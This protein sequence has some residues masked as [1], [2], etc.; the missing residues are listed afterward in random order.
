MRVAFCLGAV[1]RWAGVWSRYV[2]SCYTRTHS[3]HAGHPRATMQRGHED[4]CGCAQSTLRRA[5]T[6]PNIASPHT[7]TVSFTRPAT[8]TQRR[9][10][11]YTHTSPCLPNVSRPH[12]PKGRVYW[13]STPAHGTAPR[14]PSYAHGTAP[15][16]PT[17][18]EWTPTQMLWATTG[19]TCTATTSPPNSLWTRLV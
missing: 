8:Y 2:G 3:A 14:A 12:V 4:A 15:R 7:S 9:R 5:P 18:T 16:A 10:P 1:G 6:A 11:Y 19:H 17:C 13:A